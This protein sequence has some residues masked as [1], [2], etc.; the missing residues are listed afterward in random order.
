MGYLLTYMWGRKAWQSLAKAFAFMRND[1]FVIVKKDIMD[2]LCYRW[3]HSFFL[4]WADYN[5]W[6]SFLVRFR[7]DSW[8]G[9]GIKGQTDATQREF[10]WV[11]QPVAF[12]WT[13][14]PPW[15]YVLAIEPYLPLYAETSIC[16]PNGYTGE[17]ISGWVSR[18]YS[19]K[20]FSGSWMNSWRNCMNARR[21]FWKNI[22]FTK[23]LA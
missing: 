16:Q 7:V 10:Q 11:N 18:G 23:Y 3:S 14:R 15:L 1:W 12:L 8:A 19:A 17:S 22:S 6:S 9:C 13:D 20:T 4:V 5:S 2:Q 21:F